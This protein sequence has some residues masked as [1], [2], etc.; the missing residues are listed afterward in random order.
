[1]LQSIYSLSHLNQ[2]SVE[3]TETDT[4]VFS[5]I[6]AIEES[7][8]AEFSEIIKHVDINSYF[9]YEGHPTLLSGFLLNYCTN[10]E[11]AH[12]EEFIRIILEQKPNLNLPLVNDG[13]VPLSFSDFFRTLDKFMQD[14]AKMDLLGWG[15][16]E[17]IHSRI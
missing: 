10:P 8:I 14:S 11:L 5:L 12:G 17:I 15:E 1:M 2:N 9:D 7:E 16:Y 6:T 4:V 13:S 3:N